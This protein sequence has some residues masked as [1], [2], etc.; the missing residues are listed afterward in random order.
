MKA[1]DI[2]NKEIKEGDYVKVLT[3]DPS[4]FSNLNEQELS[5]VMSLV[6]E[7]LEVYEI[8]NYGGA[9]VSKEWQTSE[10]EI[11]SHSISL[12]K[13]EMLLIENFS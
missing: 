12:N 13:N 4:N 7:I 1:V 5:E 10:T 11:M 8:D 6:G 9:W 3:I 2:N